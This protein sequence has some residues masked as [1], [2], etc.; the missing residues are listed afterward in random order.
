MK[1]MTF[2]ERS[3]KVRNESDD[4]LGLNIK[5]YWLIHSFIFFWSEFFL[6]AFFQLWHVAYA[7]LN[8]LNS[9]NALQ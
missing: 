8:N 4:K 7:S 6:K 1:K 3:G 5:I 9:E 2:T